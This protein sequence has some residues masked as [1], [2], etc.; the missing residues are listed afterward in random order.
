LNLPDRAGVRERGIIVFRSAPHAFLKDTRGVM[1]RIHAV[2][3]LR[4][5]DY[6]LSDPGTES[7][8]EQTIRLTKVFWKKKGGCIPDRHAFAPNFNAVLEGQRRD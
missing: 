8:P 2:V 1:Q 3:G 7:I 5:C 6:R 4:R